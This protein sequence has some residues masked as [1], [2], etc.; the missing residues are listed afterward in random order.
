[1]IGCGI[2][3]ETATSIFSVANISEREP[4]ACHHSCLI[5]PGNVHLLPITYA[6]YCRELVTSRVDPF[7]SSKIAFCECQII[8][9]EEFFFCKSVFNKVN[10]HQITQDR[11]EMKAKNT[12]CLPVLISHFDGLLEINGFHGK[13]TKKVPPSLVICQSFSAIIRKWRRPF[14]TLICNQSLRKLNT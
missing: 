6:A 3:M 8:F 7:L 5:P 13:T 9:F 2:T 14:Y 1:M 4:R 10:P 12:Y 11:Y